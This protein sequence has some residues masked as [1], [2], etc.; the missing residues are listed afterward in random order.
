M[1]ATDTS[2]V[3]REIAMQP[4]AWIRA[5]DELAGVAD[6]LPQPGERVAVI[7][8]G[9]SWFMAAAY[10]SLRETRGDGETDAFAAS[11]L[12]TARSYDRVV[13]ISR[14]G[15]T[16]EVLSAIDRTTAPVTAITAVAGAPVANAAAAAIVLDFADERS[17]VQTLFATTTL[18]L[19]RASLGV[20]IDP[21]VE[22]AREILDGGERL[23]PALDTASQFSFLGQGWA[24][25]I[26]SEAALKMRE[27]ARAWTESYP[28]MEYRH[29]PISIAEPG[30]AVWVFGEPVAGLLDD[31]A[32]TGAIV[33]NDHLDP[34]ADL[35]R[36]QLLS[37]RLARGRGLDPDQPRN[38]TR[39]VVLGAV[40]PAR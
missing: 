6:R 28:Q 26:A 11:Q 16:T 33:V 13:A 18:M 9:T 5:R 17:V 30:R 3:S 10:A 20:V 15:T 34:V 7:G 22:Q 40:E 21:V 8:C 4:Q 38:L 36:V 2:H 27:A 31:I 29:G 37:V 32:T 39:S 12:P 14:S 23:D 35:V 1:T 24:A 25:G 19:L